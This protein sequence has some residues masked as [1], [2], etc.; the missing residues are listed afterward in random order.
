MLRR[1]RYLF[2]TCARPVAVLACP[3]AA[4]ACLLTA[5]AHLLTSLALVAASPVTVR[6]ARI[7]HRISAGDE[8]GVQG[9][10]SDG[11]KNG[12]VVWSGSDVHVTDGNYTVAGPFN[13]T[14]NKY[15]PITLRIDPGAI[16]KIAQS[17][18][19][20]GSEPPTACVPP[21][22]GGTA[23][24]VADNATLLVDGALITDVRDDVGDDTDG[25]AATPKPGIWLRLS[26]SNRD[27]LSNSTL[28]YIA[29]IGHVG[30]I[31]ITGNDFVQFGGIS[32]NQTGPFTYNTT[33]LVA[34]ATTEI[35]DN[36][37]EIVTGGPG[38]LDLRGT[39][40]TVVRNTFTGDGTAVV[41]GPDWG[42]IP[43]TADHKEVPAPAGGVTVIADNNVMSR[44]GFL[45]QDTFFGARLLERVPY[46]VQI[47][48]NRMHG[49]G[50]AEGVGVVLPL[51]ADVA[52]QDNV[53][54]DFAH[55]IIVSAPFSL[56]E[57]SVAALAKLRINNNRFSLE[58]VGLG[59]GPELSDPLWN[60]AGIRVNAEGNYWG[61]E[62][63][64]HD[65]STN[66]DGFTN[67]RGQG[68]NVGN[69]ID[70]EPFVGASVK[71]IDSLEI[72]ATT[73]V[74][75]PL[76]AKSNVTI[77][78]DIVRYDLLS[79]PTG[80]L[81]VLVRDQDGQILNPPG[82]NV[83]IGAASHDVNIPPIQ[84]VVPEYT[85]AITVEARIVPP[86]DILPATSNTVAFAVNPARGKFQLECI[87]KGDVSGCTPAA[88]IRG[89]D[90]NA[91][92]RF[93]YTSPNSSV[94][95]HVTVVERETG[96]GTVLASIADRTFTAPAG[97]Q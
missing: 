49:T 24:Q 27:V 76:A 54:G 60:T 37:F 72:S 26:G 66:A 93:V 38:A 45:Y 91:K 80:T 63:G 29:M 33:P 59:S 36:R 13:F 40:P 87:G 7:L 84:V 16:V 75:P 56:P 57:P 46:K 48:R 6:A 81:Q 65:T 34:G 9:K 95:A 3:L 86:G 61:H 83:A 18:T 67:A 62:S 69:G 42:Q 71:V 39:S 23:I 77:T 21:A 88:L 1:I 74:P 41:F 35:A 47:V 78:V 58:G 90:I 20:N 12:V 44:K 17:C 10:D 19:D 14:T 96:T 70:Y 64:P 79:T 94:H 15:E 50:H 55:P 11:V 97:F 92:L 52:F 31:K 22:F 89:T 4:R 68:L 28:R 73:D 8:D 82:T 32:S 30:S 2:S 43:Y 51:L 25:V 5:L 53:V 85:D